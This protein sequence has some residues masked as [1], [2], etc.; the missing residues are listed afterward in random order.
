MSYCAHIYR[1]ANFKTTVGRRPNF[2]EYLKNTTAESQTDTVSIQHGQ[3]SRTVSGA[4]C[5]RVPA[6]V[7]VSESAQRCV[8]FVTLRLLLLLYVF[9]NSFQAFSKG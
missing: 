6:A 5:R 1:W 9:I 2:I 3:K 8:L 7:R 4:N